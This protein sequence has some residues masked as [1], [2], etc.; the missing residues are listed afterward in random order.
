MKTL[1]DKVA[2]IT[3]AGSGIGRALALDLAGR[4]SRLA[5]S[6]VD[7][8]GLAD[9]VAQVQKAGVREVRSDRLDDAGVLGLGHGLGQP[10]F[11]HVGEREPRAAAGQVEGEGAADAGAGTG[12]HDHLVV[13]RLHERTSW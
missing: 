12:D 4:G 5:L 9:T 8:A 6:D 1:D 10:G 7:E 11:V 13:E 3:G 2:V